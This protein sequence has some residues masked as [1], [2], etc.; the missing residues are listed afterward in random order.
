MKRFTLTLVIASSSLL[1]L[2]GCATKAET[3]ALIGA[4]TGAVVGS[5]VDGK[6]GAVIGAGL[7]AIAGA[8][9]GGHEDRKDRER[10]GY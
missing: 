8:A 4:G 9:I 3:G 2:S 6:G 1:L 10:S 7:G 5:A